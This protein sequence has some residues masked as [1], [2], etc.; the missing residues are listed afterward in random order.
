MIALFQKNYKATTEK[1]EIYTI[2]QTTKGEVH[3]L[4]KYFKP[5][6]K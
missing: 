3:E 4:I 6:K 2:Q 5:P 1:S